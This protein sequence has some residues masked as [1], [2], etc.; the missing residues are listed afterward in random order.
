MEDIIFFTRDDRPILGRDAP[1]FDIPE[2]HAALGTRLAPPFPEG[3]EIAVF[4][5][6]CFWSAERLFWQLDGVYSTAAG[7]AGGTTP[8]PTYRETSSGRTGHAEV[9]QVVFDPERIS[10]AD[11][12][13]SFW[14]GHDPTRDHG[15]G[16]E[17]RSAIYTTT[18]EQAREAERSRDALAERGRSPISTEIAPLDAFYYAE[19]EHQQYLHEGPAASCGLHGAGTT[20]TTAPAAEPPAVPSTD[21]EWRARLS[22]EEY[23]VLRRADTERPWTGAY[24][25]VKDDGL[26]RCRG[27]GN[28]LF[29]AARKFEAGTGWPSFTDVVSP[30]AVTLRRD[31]SGTEVRCARCDSHLG[32]VFGDGPRQEG[33]L[34]YCMN[35]V[36]LDLERR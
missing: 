18:D 22:D 1:A 14:E 31:G 13:R 5:M 3:L 33:G 10:Y 32:H 24:V 16:S 21:A 35:S 28:A 11:V 12:L 34:R 19:P 17:Y 6:G 25:D 15:A 30:D 36:A 2:T 23:R 8:N 27:C 9:V 7:Y 4:G 26:Y 20:S 29:D